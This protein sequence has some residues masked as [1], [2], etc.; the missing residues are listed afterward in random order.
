MPRHLILRLEAP[1]MAFG[2]VMIDAIGP[3]RLTP[4]AASLTGMLANALGYRRWEGGRLQRL[5]ERLVFGCRVDRRG[6]RF[7]DFQ[8]VELGQ[9]DK[10]WRTDGSVERRG[11]QG[12]ADTYRSP[13]IRRRDYVADACLTIA[14]RLSD[15]D[16][17]PTLDELAT[18][19]VE[20]VR[21]LFLGRK[22]CLPAGPLFCGFVEGVTVHE[23]LLRVPPAA[24]FDG[25]LRRGRRRIDST[26]LLVL[27]WVEPM[28]VNFREVHACERRD[29]RAGVHVGDDVSFHGEVSGDAFMPN[30]PLSG[31]SV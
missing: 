10:S 2:D 1:L 5:Q 11:D 4:S 9:N 17:S 24:P 28:P 16:E 31:A 6:T 12:G 27:P 20:P 30:P 3:V 26:M 19:I 8:T 7:T 18:A 25:S 14:L 15:P 23:T 21:P 13:H 29:W 22:T